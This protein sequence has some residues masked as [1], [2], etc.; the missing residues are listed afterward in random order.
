MYKD[1]KIPD[2]QENILLMVCEQMDICKRYGMLKT[3]IKICDKAAGYFKNSSSIH[4]R[5]LL[6]RM[7][8][9][10][11]QTFNETGAASKKINVYRQIR[12]MSSPSGPP[13]IRRHSYAVLCKDN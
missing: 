1:T 10:K 5:D 3:Q 7:Q 13:Y 8:F 6:L 12:A 4:V 9:K 11:A 2:I